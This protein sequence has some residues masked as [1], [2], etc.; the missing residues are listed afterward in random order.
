MKRAHPLRALRALTACSAPFPDQ[1]THLLNA[2]LARLPDRRLAAA[3]QKAAAVRFPADV[4]PVSALARLCL[5]HSDPDTVRRLARSMPQQLAP[6][7]GGFHRS[8][9]ECASAGLHEEAVRQY[10]TATGLD[11][12]LQMTHSPS[13]CCWA[14][15]L[16]ATHRYHDA[17]DAF[18]PCTGTD[19]RRPLPECYNGLAQVLSAEVLIAE[20]NHEP[21]L[22]ILQRLADVSSPFPGNPSLARALEG[23]SRPADAAQRWRTCAESAPPADR[24]FFLT[25][26]G[27]ALRN[28]GKH[29]EARALFAEI[30]QLSDGN[31][32]AI[33]DAWLNESLCAYA[34]HRFGEEITC[35]MN[36]LEVLD[37]RD[38]AHRIR[39]LRYCA[40]AEYRLHRFDAGAAHY[41]QALDCARLLGDARLSAKIETEWADNLREHADD[42]TAASQHYTTAI[43]AFRRLLPHISEVREPLAM[44]FNGRGICA[45]HLRNYKA[46]IAD[47]TS[48]VDML[49]RMQESPEILLQ[50]SACLRNRADSLDRLGR[51]SAALSDYRRSADIYRKA[52]AAA[53]HLLDA[54]ELP[55]LLLCCGR[56]CDRMDRYDDAVRY[57]AEVLEI[58][59]K[60]PAPLNGLDLEYTVLAALRRGYAEMRSTRRNF[61]LA[62]QDF[63]YV[64]TH[65]ETTEHPNLLRIRA[66]AFRQ[67]GELYAV[68]EQY[69]LSRQALHLAAET[70]QRLQ[71][72]KEGTSDHV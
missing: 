57:Y 56:M 37:L 50:L 29:D 70:E 54:E 26:A 30:R 12:A 15:A 38:T 18:S 17:A 5:P 41:R 31:P 69:P 4:S 1:W 24:I 51:C 55:E 9:N 19:V 59:R 72:L 10:R 20:S 58:L 3:F 66:S 28:A 35:C 42:H 34:Q 47:S 63:R 67:T 2:V 49:S 43:A 22:E 36:A 6:L 27:I 65:T 14:A 48:A 33:A 7:A 44:A 46:Q 52:G 32:A 60:H 23:C 39:P 64:L 45:F 8:G 61:S 53:P 68:M 21:A 40:D 25:R 62:M 71:S 11:E 16:Y 13:R